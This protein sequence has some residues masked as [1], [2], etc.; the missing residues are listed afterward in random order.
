MIL[1]THESAYIILKGQKV[2]TARCWK[3]RRAKPGSYH[4]AQL[5][6]RAESR[7]ARLRIL[8]VEE[9]DGKSADKHFAKKE[10]YDSS[11]EFLFSYWSLNDHIMR[12]PDRKHYKIEFKVIDIFQPTPP[13]TIDGKPH[14]NKDFL[15]YKITQLEID[16]QL[17]LG[18]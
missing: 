14:Y 16:P 9:W 15:K 12:D 10:G 4:Y 5:N 7:F 8:S 1:F 3:R 2:M 13:I 11:T 17:L 6:R 18:A